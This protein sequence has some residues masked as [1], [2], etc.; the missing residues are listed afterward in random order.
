MKKNIYI[1]V[2]I[3]VG[4]ISSNA[5]LEQLLLKGDQLYRAQE[6]DKAVSLYNKALEQSP[7][8][9][10]VKE[11]LAEVYL[12]PGAMYSTD[13]A[14]RYMEDAYKTGKMSGV[15]QS[16]YVS[17]LQSQRNFEKASE[18]ILNSNRNNRNKNSLMNAADVSYYNKLSTLKAGIIIQ[19]LRDINS[20]YSDFSPSFYGSGLAFISTRSNRSNTG[21]K[22]S[23]ILENYSDV[24]TTNLTTP[25]TQ[26]F[27]KPISMLGNKNLKYMQ[28]P[29]AFT[30]DQTNMFITRSFVKDDNR[31]KVS[32]E[33]RRTTMLEIARLSQADGK[34][35]SASSVIFN[36]SADAQNYSYA[37]PT[38][39]NPNGTEIIFSSNMPGGFGGSDLW[40]SKSEGSGWST[41][42]NLGPE[43]NT[44]GEEVFPYYSKDK[45]LYFASSGLPGLGG[46]DL[47]KT[48]GSIGSYSIPENLGAPFNSPYD[49]FG[50]IT[51]EGND[52]YLTSNRPNGVGEDDIYYWSNPVCNMS[53]KV[54]DA[55]TNAPIPN[56]T[57][58]IPCT[59]KSYTTDGRGM[60]Q[61]V[62]FDTKTCEIAS[63]AT[64]Y[65]PKNMSLQSLDDV[66]LINI[67]MDKE[68][69]AVVAAPSSGC[70]FVITVVDKET[71]LPI[72][73]ANVNMKGLTTPDEAN[74]LSKAEGRFKVTGMDQSE[75]YRI[76]ASKSNDDGSKFIGNAETI[77]CRMPKTANGDVVK[78][79]YLSRAKVGSK[80]KIE[81]IYYDLDKWNIKPRAAQELDNIVNIMKSYPTME[82]E[83]GSHTDCR[84]TMKYNEVLSSKRAASAME[85]II[86]KGVDRQRMSSKGYGESELTN[87][88][89]CEGVNKSTCSEDEH[90][91]NRRTEFKI[92]KF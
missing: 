59:N 60:I 86:S 46:L 20:E 89:A 75:T 32:S 68:S 63:T 45:T 74:G 51:K 85:Y 43:I 24:F 40:Y 69:P 14:M 52:G 21:F 39:L 35:S 92:I 88:C 23:Q 78:T 65:Y 76:S 17:L 82:I 2:F 5:Q 25:A 91:S 6:L 87:G 72:E 22:L 54:Y 79:I 30:G 61:V 11:K 28:G 36:S 81:N 19:N 38:L 56:A 9:V 8:S 34:W 66:K 73:G 80:F 42:V 77:S 71:N 7:E 83:M 64:G 31:A 48:S 1:L 47:Y 33:D 29:M 62:C 12:N 15:L 90:Q 41:P 70:R 49:D 53:V 50:L 37:H 84:A 44:G 27:D 18:V 26:T 3:L 55:K 13:M 58:K 57:V 16:K 4:S 67:P 10:I